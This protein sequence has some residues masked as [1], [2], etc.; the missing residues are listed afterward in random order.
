MTEKQEEKQPEQKQPEC[1]ACNDS[2]ID[3]RS[4]VDLDGFVHAF[5]CE[6]CG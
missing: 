6:E 2:G 4:F 3:A 5:P 1:L